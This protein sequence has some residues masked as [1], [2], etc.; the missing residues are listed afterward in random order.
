MAA[1]AA[2]NAPSLFGLTESMLNPIAQP[3]DEPQIITVVQPVGLMPDTERGVVWIGGY[4]I[5][6]RGIQFRDDVQVSRDEWQ[7]LIPVIAAIQTAYQWIIA[8]WCV[9]G[10]WQWGETYDVMAALVKRDRDTLYNWALVSRRIQISRRREISFSHHV[11]VA[12]FEDEA[13]QDVWLDLA[14]NRKWSRNTLRK[15]IVQTNGN[16]RLVDHALG[17]PPPPTMSVTPSRGV[18]F[19]GSRE[20]VREL[21]KIPQLLQQ[22]SA[23]NERARLTALG[24]VAFQR[25]LLD[26]VEARLKGE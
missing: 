1:G 24:W 10:E 2:N 23:G 20:S 3:V 8:D 13:L 11:E 9:Y 16:P 19:I 7:G 18:E 17:D 15:M 6:N 4:G 14:V 12:A 5:T 22:A 26:Q 21:R 25:D